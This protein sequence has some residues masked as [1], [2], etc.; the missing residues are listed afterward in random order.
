M[1]AYVKYK[2]LFSLL[3]TAGLSVHGSIPPSP[4][5]REVGSTASG[6]VHAYPS[7]WEPQLRSQAQHVIASG[8]RLRHSPR[9]GPLALQAAL[10]LTVRTG[11]G[12]GTQATAST[13]APRKCL[14]RLRVPPVVA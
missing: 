10:S 11:T 5:L 9:R 13:A 8:R 1:S 3:C 4:S 14:H 6:I 12:T 2:I 7:L